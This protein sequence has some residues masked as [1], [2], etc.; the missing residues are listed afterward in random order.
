MAK[1]GNELLE[2]V[3]QQKY[4][5][6]FVTNIESDKA[7]K[8][9]NEDIIRFISSKKNE[10]EWRTSRITTTMFPVFPKISKSLKKLQPRWKS[11]GPVPLQLEVDWFA[12]QHINNALRVC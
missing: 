4:K 2:E 6:G 11:T 12:L 5:Y 7:P 10:P 8:G 9:L 3:T 1:P